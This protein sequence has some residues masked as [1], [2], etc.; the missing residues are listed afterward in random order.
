MGVGQEAQDTAMFRELEERRFSRM[1]D[2]L[3]RKLPSCWPTSS[4]RLEVRA[5]YSISIM[6]SK[7]FA[8]NDHRHE[9]RT[10]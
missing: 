3:R 8:T 7:L 2:R 4:S 9:Q 6:S 1:S 5:E 10:A